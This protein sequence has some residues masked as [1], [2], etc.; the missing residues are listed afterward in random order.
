MLLPLLCLLSSPMPQDSPSPPRLRDLGITIGSLEPGPWNAITDVAGVGVGH[1][2]LDAG[3]VQTGVTVI[4]PQLEENPHQRKLPAAVFTG[5]GYGK[6][7]GFT[8]VQELGE[9]EAPIVLTNTLSVGTALE[10][11]VARMLALPGNEQVRSVN[12]VVGETND[13]WLNDIR[14]QHVGPSHVDAAWDAVASGPVVEGSVGAGR[15]TIC[16]GFKGGIGTSSRR[17]GPYTVGVLVQTNFGG[18]L[19]VDGRALP[20]EGAPTEEDGSCMIVVATD[21]P[22]LDRNLER[23][24]RRA[25]LG[26]GRT[27]SVMSNGSGDYVIA[28]STFAGNR[29]HADRRGPQPRTS[30]SNADMTP[31]FQATVEATEEAV[32]NSLVAAVTVSGRDGH[33]V[34]ALDHA[35]LRALVKD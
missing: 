10:A 8:Q 32:L 29:V 20:R 31:L 28:F 7:A 1:A 24:A 17:V 34:R 21:A 26:L 6:A 33:R 19:R 3:A 27:G 16:F 30:L 2:T 4:W 18:R 14:G 22:I 35:R 5:N 13:G 15:G 12:V 9:L 25:L 11:A 23:L